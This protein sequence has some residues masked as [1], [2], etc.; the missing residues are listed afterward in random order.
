MN[1]TD[2]TLELTYEV[3]W[4]RKKDKYIVRPFIGLSLTPPRCVGTKQECKEWVAQHN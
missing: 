2:C 3:V 4:S 1:T